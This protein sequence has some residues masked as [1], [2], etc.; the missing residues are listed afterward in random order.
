MDQY[1]L[2][3]GAGKGIGRSLAILLAQ[4]GYNL[5]LVSRTE[6][7]LIAL[8]AQIKADY[9]VEAD[10]VAI[11]LSAAG[12]SLRI[13][14]WAKNLNVPLSI[15]INNAGHGVWG[16][17]HE[18]DL[19]AQTGMMQVNMNALTELSYYFI[20][21]LKLQQQAFILNV[22]STAA[23][24]AVPTLALYAATKAFV[25]SFSRALRY[26]L[27][28]TTIAVS[29]LCPGPTDTGFVHRA[30]MD[31][32]ADLAAKFSMTADD[33]AAMGVK[34][35]FNK[36]AEIVPGLLNKLSVTGSVHLP[37][38]IIERIAAGLYKR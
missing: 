1:A 11:D 8:S 25:L 33:V 15:L 7:D 13:F 21:I 37:K 38:S 28:D 26:E 36:K 10:Y 27:K 32:I 6:S 20:P 9:K 19:A 35:M 17:F 30:G 3:T 23:Y 24:Q 31:A 2:V 5:L 16:N 29:C 12:A 14:D 22:G 34:G 18:L 4:K